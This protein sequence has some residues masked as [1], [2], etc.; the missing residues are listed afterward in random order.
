MKGNPFADAPERIDEGEEQ[1]KVKQ[2]L[3]WIWAEHGDKT[4]VQL[5]DETHALGTP[6]RQIAEKYNFRVPYDVDISPERDWAFFAKLAEQRGIQTV[7][8]IA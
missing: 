1:E 2:M 3:D 7:P 8:F 6:W 4:A 5:S